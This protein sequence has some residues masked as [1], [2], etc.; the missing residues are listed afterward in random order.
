MRVDAPALL[1]NVTRLC[2]QR[3]LLSANFR[4]FLVEFDN[5]FEVP[6]LPAEAWPVRLHP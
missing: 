3:E 2:G 4:R 1:A 5:S 6:L